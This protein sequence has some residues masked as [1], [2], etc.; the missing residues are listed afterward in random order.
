MLRASPKIVAVKP[1][2]G[3]FDSPVVRPLSKARYGKVFEQDAAAAANESDD[4]GPGI[5]PTVAL[6]GAV[7]PLAEKVF[8]CTTLVRPVDPVER[9]KSPV[10]R[11]RKKGIALATAP[12]GSI[13]RC[14]SA[15]AWEFSLRSSHAL[16]KAITSLV[17]DRL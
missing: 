12:D 3:S 11:V 10:S 16:S 4:Q 2:G 5:R 6:R 1:T 9:S 17:I 15:K 7:V 8:Y 13:G 14:P